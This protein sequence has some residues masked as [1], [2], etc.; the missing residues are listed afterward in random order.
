MDS[1]R[2]EYNKALKLGK[3][4]YH[5][6]L[7]RGDSPYLPVLDHMIQNTSIVAQE[8]LGIVEIPLDQI[9][10]TGYEG[11]QKVF[12]HGFMPIAEEDTE[13]AHK[14]M[15]LC[16]AHLE[17]GIRDPIVAYEFMN[18][19]YVVEGHK[20][21]SVLRHF[22]AAAV[23][24][25][26][27]RVIPE[28]DQTEESRIYEEFLSFYRITK[29]NYLWFSNTGSF[30][31]LLVATGST[32][33]EP[34]DEDRRRTFQSF[35]SL[36]SSCYREKEKGRLALTVG[37]AMLV[38]LN[39]YDYETSITKPKSVVRM[40]LSRI[41]VEICNKDADADIH[42]VLEPNE[43][44]TFFPAVSQKHMRVAF[45]HDQT[46]SSSSWIY[47]HELGRK[48]LEAAFHGQVETIA[49][50]GADT[51]AAAEKA[52]DAAIADESDLIFTT[53]PRLLN[54]S[55]KAA[56][57]NPKVKI[58]NCSLNTSHPAIR[59]Y[60]ARMYEA[61]F[62]MGVIAG[63]L[64]PD[65]KIGYIADCPIY[66]ITANINAFALGA[67]MV[68][69]RA[70]IFLEWSG[71][72]EQDSRGRLCRAGISYISDQDMITP[73]REDSHHVGLYRSDGDA[74]ENT[75]LTIWRWGK[76]YE[77]IVRNYLRGGWRADT[78]GTRAVNYWWG[79]DAGVIDLICS[80]GLPEETLRLVQLFRQS[81]CS[82]LFHPFDG[83]LKTQSGT[84][85]DY[86][87]DSITPEGIITMDWLL[88]NVVGSLPA[89]DQ[90]LPETQALVRVQG[91]QKHEN[92]SII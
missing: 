82:G 90:L 80:R 17:E 45:I 68:N 39:I 87:Q 13:F 22:G 7:L 63:S 14:W 28:P 62:L 41:W 85:M 91:I 35:Y 43:Y 84:V 52:I 26:V 9:A 64:T 33:D 71:T 15:T 10:G 47:A 1:A 81:I 3:K 86:R 59:T 92:F 16:K 53:S 48:D 78:D 76:L 70:Q 23:R 75:A 50:D 89:F 49:L 55:V 61:K 12:T 8:S 6:S 69:P 58:L 65:N 5:S 4:I 73:E 79:I 18:H 11:R 32:T 34:W 57:E 2:E 19:F 36:F 83:L 46:A 29:I 40:E 66:G 67:K 77:K 54:A 24:G 51:D 30:N 38:Y 44:R 31:A 42:L 74:L 21:V 20:R 37:D 60:Y 72:V 25:T 56:L 88:D 27:T